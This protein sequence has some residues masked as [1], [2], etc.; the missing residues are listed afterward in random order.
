MDYHTSDTC[1]YVELTGGKLPPVEFCKNGCE[2]C[3][4]K[5]K[6]EKHS[7]VR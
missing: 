5:N 2:D 6:D 7:I 3:P 4:F 1:T